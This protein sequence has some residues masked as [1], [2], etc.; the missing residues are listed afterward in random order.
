MPTNWCT[1]CDYCRGRGCKW[2]KLTAPPV[3][4]VDDILCCRR[5]GLPRRQL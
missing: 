4:L 5:C 2:C 1:C 3:D